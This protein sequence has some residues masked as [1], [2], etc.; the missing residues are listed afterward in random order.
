MA[1]N[2]WTT[3]SY[4]G[5][6]GITKENVET[7]SLRKRYIDASANNMTSGDYYRLFYYPANTIIKR[8]F[9]VTETVEGAADTID[10]TDDESGSNTLVSNH[11]LNTDNAIGNYS[12][13]L[14]KNTAGYIS[15]KP[16]AALTVCKFWVGVELITVSTDD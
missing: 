15:A 12:T 16:D 10:I 2:D 8:V 6:H 7:V 14:F 3:S 13:G 1:V 9:I 5:N 11:D 4:P